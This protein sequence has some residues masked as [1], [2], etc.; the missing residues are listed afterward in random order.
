MQWGIRLPLVC[1]HVPAECGI[2]SKPVR[3]SAVT[4]AGYELALGGSQIC[5]IWLLNTLMTESH[6]S[7]G[8]KGTIKVSLAAVTKRRDTGCC[9]HCNSNDA[10]KVRY[11][12][13]NA[14][15]NGWRRATRTEERRHQQAHNQSD[16]RIG[17]TMLKITETPGPS[18][19][20]PMAPELQ[21]HQNHWF[22]MR[23][24]KKQS[25]KIWASTNAAAAGRAKRDSTP[26]TLHLK[27][28]K[29]TIELWTSI[30]ATAAGRAK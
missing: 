12:R 13:K 19:H 9:W 30:T 7:I 3:S 2:R 28:R 10:G 21:G 16:S 5:N 8:E 6:I 18:Q 1:A 23:K 20:S 27:N 24:T 15:W 11:I 26:W 25:S 17:L 29:T 4:S 14:E 22:R